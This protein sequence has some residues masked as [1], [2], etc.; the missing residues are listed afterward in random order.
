MVLPN[1]SES[2]FAK[3]HNLRF[4]FHDA[5]LNRVVEIVRMLDDYAPHTAIDSSE[6][7]LNLRYHTFIY[8]SIG[9]KSGETLTIDCRDYTQVVIHIGEYAIL[10]KAEDEVR[11]LNL[12]GRHGYG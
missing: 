11:G 3:S 10:L 7:S 4:L 6:G 9:T 5:C 12:R 8:R 1:N 2:F